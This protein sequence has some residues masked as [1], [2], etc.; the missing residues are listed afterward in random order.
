MNGLRWPGGRHRFQGIYTPLISLGSVCKSSA[1][2]S[3]CLPLAFLELPVEMRVI[4]ETNLERNFEDA[5]IGLFEQLGCHGNPI[6]VDIVGHGSTGGASKES[7][8]RR[9]AKIH[10]L[11]EVLI[12][13]RL[14]V[15]LAQET[16][17]LSNP[18]LVFD[19]RGEKIAIANPPSQSVMG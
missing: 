15:V 2:D 11:R 1:E 10:F 9:L 14:I 3:G 17:D 4:P 13:D 7:A 18:L 12:V 6:F 8:Q 16:A 5:L 19:S